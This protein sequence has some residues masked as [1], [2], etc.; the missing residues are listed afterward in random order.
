MLGSASA[1]SGVM[2]LI[3]HG[4]GYSVKT[5]P[6]RD[7]PTPLTLT[8]R[9]ARYATR[10]GRLDVVA[11]QPQRANL[12]FGTRLS[13]PSRGLAVI[14]QP[15]GRRGRL[16]V[17]GFLRVGSTEP[18]L[19]PKTTMEMGVHRVHGRSDR[20][21]GY[22]APSTASYCTPRLAGHRR[23]WAACCHPAS[24]PACR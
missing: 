2:P 14:F 16:Y 3:S 11:V 21:T 18:L 13:P 8:Q 10:V 19:P 1:A 4:S 5:Q 23:C 15:R 12:R 6:S 17:R 9:P 24:R 22:D 7:S 20:D